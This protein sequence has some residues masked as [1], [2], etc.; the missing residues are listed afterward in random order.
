MVGRYSWCLRLKVCTRSV[1]GSQVDHRDIYDTFNKKVFGY[2]DKSPQIDVRPQL[3][4]VLDPLR[5]KQ[6]L[7]DKNTVVKD[8]PGKA[9]HKCKMQKL[10]MNLS[11]AGKNSKLVLII[12]GQMSLTLY[13]AWVSSL[14]YTWLR[15]LGFYCHHKSS[16][17]DTESE[18]AGGCLLPLLC[19]K[20]L[21][22]F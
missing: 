10:M 12:E 4:V 13:P 7:K 8:D 6:L 11:T 5:G 19:K 18:V 1:V 21:F 9:S 20:A 15:T 16:M 17:A 14:V 2:W 22:S 3:F